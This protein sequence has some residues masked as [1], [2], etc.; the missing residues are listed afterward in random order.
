MLKGKGGKKG[1]LWG[2]VVEVSGGE[3]YYRGA[4]RICDE[5]MRA[6]MKAT[7]MPELKS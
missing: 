1:V 5:A 2:E 3:H 7:D 6:S 4:P